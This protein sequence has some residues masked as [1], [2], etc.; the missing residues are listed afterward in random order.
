MKLDMVEERYKVIDGLIKK[1]FKLDAL[2]VRD[3]ENTDDWISNMEIMK[4]LISINDLIHTEKI[5]LDAFYDI[6]NVRSR[7]VD[8]KNIYLSICYDGLTHFVDKILLHLIEFTFDSLSDWKYK[9]EIGQKFHKD[10]S[11]K[12]NALIKKYQDL[13]DL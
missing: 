13:Y 6:E 7:N 4:N 9:T 10:V 1:S 5:F 2:W 3:Q 11:K 8:E 12:L